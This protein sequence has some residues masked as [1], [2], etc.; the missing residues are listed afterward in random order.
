MSER[1]S[2][3]KIVPTLG[4]TGATMNAMAL[5]APGAFLWITY[6]MQASATAPSGASVA[7]DIWPGIL[8]A[9]AVAILTALSYAQLARIY[10]EAGFASAAYFAEKAFIDNTGGKSKR[11]AVSAARIS[12][13]ATGWGAHLFYWVY[14]GIMVA[15][16]ATM[17]GYLYNQFT[18]GTLSIPVL[19]MIAT[20]I[21]FVIG[22]IAYRG[23]TGSTLVSIWINV[24]QWV[25]LVVFSLLAIYYRISNPQ[26]A[27]AWSFSGV[28]DVVKPHSATGVLVQ[29]TIAILILVGFES[30]TALAAETKEPEKNIPKAIII[31]LVV[32]GAFAY[33][34]EYLAA[35]LMVSDK[36][37]LVNAGKTLTGLDAA[38]ASSAPIGDLA[39]LLGDNLLHGLG[40]GLMI[41]I[42]ITVIIAIIGTTLSC[43][44]TAVRISNGMAE[45]RELPEFIGFMSGKF[46]TPHTAIW[47]LVIVTS[48]IGAIGVQSVVGLTGITLASNLGTF[49]LYGLICVWTVVAFK[50]RSDFSALKHL[51]IP[52]LGV[53]ANII[54]IVAILYL[55]IVGG[56]ASKT[57]AEICFY[58]AGGWAL[59]SIGY[60]IMTSVSK[61]YGMKMISAIIRP[62]KLNVLVE[63]LKDEDLIIGMTA[64]RVEGFG[65]Q[66]GQSAG[67]DVADTIAFIPKVRVDIVVNDWDLPKVMDIIQEV[68]QSGRIGDGKVFVLDA[69]EAMRIRTGEKG[70]YA[71]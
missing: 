58:I 28:V 47:T 70:V 50:K 43:M 31:A 42:A 38:G 44:N 60:V 4:L 22:Y 26:H 15:T 27:A 48:I 64:T 56:A 1:T 63:V 49:V 14:P 34:F 18:G 65:R 46:S 69:K 52:V 6:Q 17:C 2:V 16:F 62:E 41:T 10:P 45:D 59:I 3:P 20:V 61:T 23:V 19:V 53:I 36:Y 7:M 35:G 68:S 55:Y 25:S 13:L 8:A 32:Q 5:I 54:M 51:V 57:E 9:L 66:K 24:I 39:K 29:A 40:F 12:K 37:S 11:G 67:A 33:L 71:L 30:C 21:A